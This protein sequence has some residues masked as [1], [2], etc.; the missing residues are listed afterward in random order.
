MQQVIQINLAG[1]LIP[2][3]EDACSVLKEY[4]SSLKRQ[5]TG[6]EGKEI[7]EDI[8]NRIAELFTIRLQSGA[9]AIDKADV[10]KVKETLGSASELKDEDA[11]TGSSSSS[12]PKHT[13]YT[14]T[15]YQQP[16]QRRLLRNPFDKM[17]GGV[18]SGMAIYFDIDPVI[19]RL[20][21]AVLFFSLGI[22]LFAYIIAWIIIPAARTQEELYNMHGGNPVTFQDMSSSF[23]DDLEDLKRRG[24]QMSRD[25]KDFFSKKK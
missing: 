13:G 4:I 1:R 6:E 25:L 11:A 15:T 18:C 7:I 23:H 9:V 24:E 5:F 19:I 22:G 20:I 8:E 12:G 2:I 21:M 17:V 16:P 10:V 14:H 3:E